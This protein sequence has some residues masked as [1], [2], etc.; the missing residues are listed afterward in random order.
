M[1]GSVGSHPDG[2]IES[3]FHRTCA[4]ARDAKALRAVW[5]GILATVG[6]VGLVSVAASLPK[7]AGDAPSMHS[8]CRLELG[9]A[10]E[11][12]RPLGRANSDYGVRSCSPTGTDRLRL[13]LN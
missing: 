4:A 5:T 1:M 13:L 6:A 12:A 9:P 11:I 7:Q 2:C 10:A 3:S 8:V